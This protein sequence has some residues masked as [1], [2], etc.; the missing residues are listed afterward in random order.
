MASMSDGLVETDWGAD[1]DDS[2]SIYG[3]ECDFMEKFNGFSNPLA[4][5]GSNGYGGELLLHHGG[6]SLRSLQSAGAG[7]ADGERS[8][9]TSPSQSPQLTPR[10][11]TTGGEEWWE[12]E[13]AR[14]EGSW[15]G[16]TTTEVA[17][18]K[19][20][21]PT[22]AGGASTS[23]SGGGGDEDSGGPAA[24]TQTGAAAGYPPPQ[25][26]SPPPLHRSGSAPSAGVRTAGGGASSSSGSASEAGTTPGDLALRAL[27]IF[28]RPPTGSHVKTTRKY[29]PGWKER[30]E[31]SGGVRGVLQEMAVRNSDAQVLEGAAD[32]LWGAASESVECRE[33]LV[34]FNGLAVLLQTLALWPQSSG[35]SGAVAGTLLALALNS[36]AHRSA[37]AEV[38]GARAIRAVMLAHPSIGY[39]GSYASLGSWLKAALG[40]EWRDGTEEVFRGR[41]SGSA[42]AEAPAEPAH[43]SELL[44][45]VLTPGGVHKA[46]KSATPGSHYKRMSMWVTPDCQKLCYSYDP[47]AP[48]AGVPPA[49]HRTLALRDL[50][51]IED[52]HKT[53]ALQ[54]HA[55][56]NS[57]SRSLTL[58]FLTE[59][60][61]LNL[62]F[63]SPSESSVWMRA[64]GLLGVDAF[65]LT[66][67]EIDKRRHRLGLLRQPE[68][69][70]GLM[71]MEAALDRAVVV[72]KCACQPP[73]AGRLCAEQAMQLQQHASERLGAVRSHALSGRVLAEQRRLH[74]LQ[75]DYVEHGTSGKMANELK[76]EIATCKRALAIAREQ[77]SDMPSFTVHQGLLSVSGGSAGGPPPGG[78]GSGGAQ[79]TPTSPTATAPAPPSLKAPFL[80][81]VR[82]EANLGGGGGGGGARPLFNLADED[83]T[84]LVQDLA[85]EDDTTVSE[86]AEELADATSPKDDATMR[87]RVT[88]AGAIEPLAD[89]L[90]RGPKCAWRSSA[91]T[92]AHLAR[93]KRLQ[94]EVGDSGCIPFLVE[95]LDLQHMGTPHDSVDAALMALVNLC[96]NLAE[97]REDCLK[98]GGMAR[99]L[100]LMRGSG[101]LVS[102]KTLQACVLLF[103]SLCNIAGR[104]LGS[105][106]PAGIVVV[107]T[108]MPLLDH[109]DE[110]LRA[111][112]LHALGSLAKESWQVKNAVR[113]EGVLA[114]A[115]RA[116]CNKNSTPALLVPALALLANALQSCNP[117][118]AYLRRS[119]SQIMPTLRHLLGKGRTAPYARHVW[120]IVQALGA[121]LSDRQ[122]KAL[123]QTERAAKEAAAQHQSLL[124]ARLRNRM[125][126]AARL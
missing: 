21:A 13:G 30:L 68:L 3:S 93:E 83:I 116:V 51:E 79:S 89:I 111:G 52:G 91:Y 121:V 66:N 15:S 5:E 88:D 69:P 112:M 104:T 87:A 105:T 80:A 7:S 126:V 17:G 22:G 64:L 63:D 29:A 73:C 28:A 55:P 39:G 120:S 27:R 54:K 58:R 114:N 100:L 124:W 26:R 77:C 62:V 59:E 40:R 14:A 18:A 23:E 106:S 117:N 38:G 101:E 37:V 84:Q 53:E 43:V 33:E 47:V 118:A 76:A 50:C 44:A 122:K 8:V 19:A 12:R 61:E 70:D 11:V 102:E 4:E 78:G 72:A 42:A 123:K 67:F 108:V 2:A 119:D 9:G 48:G 113:A 24:R 82:S 95:L 74:R 98:A 97:N 32:A 60:K 109:R 103:R 36:P 35:L 110:K 99:L 75:Q 45:F 20:A 49:P 92:L 10:S 86:A 107:Q 81:G 46:A 65:F 56:P 31:A 115:V 1:S 125:Y 6:G 94:K 96:S 90:D 85:S 16:A 25:S 71:E 34:Q 57:E 41:L